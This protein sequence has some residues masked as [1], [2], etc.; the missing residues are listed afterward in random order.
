M[1]NNDVINYVLKRYRINKRKL[2]SRKTTIAESNYCG[3]VIVE[4]EK[5]LK[6]FKIQVISDFFRIFA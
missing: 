2:S 3:T 1:N 5:I 4:L 6:H